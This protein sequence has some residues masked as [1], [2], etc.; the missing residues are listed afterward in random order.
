NSF[1]QRVSISKNNITLKDTF[2]EIHQ[3]TGYY[4]IY[5][6]KVVSNL[7]ALNLDIKNAELNDALKEIFNHQPLQYTIEDK[8]I[9]IK[10]KT[11]E[12]S[13]FNNQQADRVLSGKV[14]DAGDGQP[15]IGVTI[16]IKGRNAGTMSNLNGE[17]SITV[18]D[19]DKVLIFTYL[20]YN[21][22]EVNITKQTNIYNVSMGS[23]DT[24]LQE[25]VVAFGSSSKREL[26]HS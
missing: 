20:G 10:S 14:V 23:A 24:Q 18:K 9:V 6:D 25:V 13:V 4:F 1:A 11:K 16:K 3:Q 26:T 2:R 15:L 21:A 19:N 12:R 5:N 7:K 17:F 8:I 22:K